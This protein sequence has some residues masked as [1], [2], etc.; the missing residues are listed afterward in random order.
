MTKSC[1]RLSPDYRPWRT[2]L[3]AGFHSLLFKASVMVIALIMVITCIGTTLSVQAFSE[4]LNEKER[5]ATRQW[6]Q[7]MA[8]PLAAAVENADRDYLER[9]A[10]ELME[11]ENI[12]CIIVSDKTGKVLASTED[13]EGLLPVLLQHEENR[14]KPVAS[15]TPKIIHH[16]RT[17]RPYVDVL[18]PI[19]GNSKQSNTLSKNMP[20]IGYLHLA[21]DASDMYAKLH[22]LIAQLGKIALGA[23][24]VVVPI[25]LLVT[26]RFVIPLNKLAQTAQA[27]SQGA[28]DARAP[29]DSRDEIGQ[30]AN[31]FNTM[32]DRVA[33]SQIELLQLNAEL[34][35]RVQQRTHD[36]KRLATQDPLTGLYNRRHFTEVMSREFAA[37]ER[38]DSD[39]TCLMFDLDHF[40]Q[41]NDNHGHG[42][43]DEVLMILAD[44]ISD[45]LRV[46]DMA[47][48]FGGDEFIVL[49]PQTSVKAASK[50][51]ERIIVNFEKKMKI[52][53]PDLPSTMSI[54]AASLRTTRARS[55]EALIHAADTTM[56]NAKQAGRNQVA[57]ASAPSHNEQMTV[58]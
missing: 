39:L 57:I 43:G 1:T 51:A 23:I 37:A 17:Q 25:S 27:I 52:N 58:G 22:N 48:R 41:I 53:Y 56:Y 10:T 33:H 20:I 35:E 46:S 29:V 38:Y 31:S 42:V 19:Y 4:V 12:G 11:T 6:A 54:G 55:Y 9:L 14:L 47:A 15:N 24:A 45:S 18:V 36:L 44:T 7:T 26:R 16:P 5:F 50:L 49:L 30:L 34:E 13:S 2:H 28:M 8:C 32:A 3:K 21:T 40:K